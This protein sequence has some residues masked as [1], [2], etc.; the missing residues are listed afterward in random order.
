LESVIRGENS[1]ILHVNLAPHFAEAPTSAEHLL[2]R[3]V[4]TLARLPPPISRGPNFAVLESR[5]N[6][7]PCTQILNKDR[8]L[9]CFDGCKILICERGGGRRGGQCIPT[10]HATDHLPGGL[11]PLPPLSP[12]LAPPLSG[13]LGTPSSAP[14]LLQLSDERPRPGWLSSRCGITRSCLP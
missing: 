2:A 5:I 13:P 9:S 1:S 10:D 14:P 4:P 7:Q 3:A 12:G 11:R 8:T 6:L